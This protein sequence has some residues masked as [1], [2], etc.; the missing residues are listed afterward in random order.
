M[1][2]EIEKNNYFRIEVKKQISL[3]INYKQEIENVLKNIFNILY[4]I[5]DANPENIIDNLK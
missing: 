2:Y 1:K 3:D 4:K 5:K